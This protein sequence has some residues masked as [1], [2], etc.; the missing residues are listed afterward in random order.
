M[1]IEL[2]TLRTRENCALIKHFTGI[3]KVGSE[4]SASSSG[5]F[6]LFWFRFRFIAPSKANMEEALSHARRTETV[7]A[8]TDRRQWLYV[9]TVMPP[10]L[11]LKL[12]DLE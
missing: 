10:S 8:I 5:C 7:D 11:V 2:E 6:F 1:L 3:F 9:L 4:S 12:L